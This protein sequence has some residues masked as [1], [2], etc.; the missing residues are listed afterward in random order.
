MAARHIEHAAIAFI[1]VIQSDPAREVLHG[2]GACP[3]RII[4]M[5][6]HH[7][8][9]VS[10]LAEQLVMPETDRAS[11]ELGGGQGKGRIPQGIVKARTQAPAAQGVEE[12][13]LGLTGLVGMILIPP[14]AP[15][16]IGFKECVQ[17]LSQE[18]HLRITQ[19]R[20]AADKTLFSVVVELFRGKRV[21][22]PLLCLVWVGKV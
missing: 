21:L 22:R 14:L 9:M 13:L 5:P 16:M 3:V 2:T 6:G 11:Q 1:G 10:R 4:L 8:T 17:L 19:Q 20:N 18:I 7:T 12:N 15:R